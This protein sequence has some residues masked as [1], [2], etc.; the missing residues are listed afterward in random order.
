M[1]AFFSLIKPGIIF[2]N[3]VT[4]AGGFLLGAALP[5]SY[6]LFLFTLVGLCCIIA[7]AAIVNNY[8]DRDID[9]K[10]DRTENRPLVTKTISNETALFLALLFGLAGGFLL[11][12]Q[13]THLAFFLAL[14]G[15]FVYLVPYSYF[16]YRSVYGTAVGSIAGGIPVLVGYCAAK[17]GFDLGGFILFILMV[18]WQMPHFYAIAI[19]RQSDYKAASIPVLPLEKGMLHT[20]IEMICYI[21]AFTLTSLSLTF[22]GYTGNAFAILSLCFGAA[23][24]GLCFYGFYIEGSKEKEWG[25]KM[26]FL[27]L[28][29]IMI[30]FAFLPFDKL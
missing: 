5:F 13:S 24:L 19:Y 7:S 15:F 25:K 26:L 6:S 29:I 10:M 17:G 18:F 20:K 28:W 11:W 3:A 27:S 23:W 30:Q 4:A 9:A 12:T 1:K 22:F 14:F 2:G 16:K 21:I 8:L